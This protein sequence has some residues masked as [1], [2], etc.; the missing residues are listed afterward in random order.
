MFEEAIGILSVAAISG[1]ARR[2]YVRDFV[3]IR[4]EHAQESLWSHGASAN[5]DVVRLLHDRSAL[6]EER[7]ELEDELLES[8]RIGF[9]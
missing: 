5:F 4:S 2:L 1:T 7:L 8:R 9:G 6:G 3:R